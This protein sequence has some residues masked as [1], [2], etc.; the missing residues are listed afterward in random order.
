MDGLGWIESRMML[1]HLDITSSFFFVSMRTTI[2][3]DEDLLQIARSLARVRSISI[4]AIVSELVRR[5]LEMQR[6]SAMDRKSGFPIFQVSQDAHPITLE[7][8]KKG[9]DE[10]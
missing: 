8:V 6:Q 5:G 10:P 1:C 3:I 9:E 4:G 7:D 2:N